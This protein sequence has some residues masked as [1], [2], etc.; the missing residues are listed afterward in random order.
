MLFIHHDQAQRRGRS[1]DGRTR[2]DDHRRLARTNPLPLVPALAYRQGAV[3]NRYSVAE[4]GAV[5]ADRLRGQRDLGHQH[6]RLPTQ[7]QHPLDGAE[8]HLRLPTRR[9]PVE[10]K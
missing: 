10:E 8:E 4:S 6:D 9:H 3:Q 7:C 5:D 2:S 1:K